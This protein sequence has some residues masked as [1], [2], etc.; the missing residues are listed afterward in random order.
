MENRP[1]CFTELQDGD[2]EE[3]NRILVGLDTTAVISVTDD[4]DP[5]DLIDLEVERANKKK[6]KTERCQ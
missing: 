1:P 3:S 5:P 4:Q 2:M 6:E